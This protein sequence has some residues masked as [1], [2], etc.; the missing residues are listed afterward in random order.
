M[1]RNQQKK[2]TFDLV[3]DTA[4]RLTTQ[5]GVLSISI[6]AIAKEAGCSVAT[7]YRHF[8]TKEDIALGLWNRF[9]I[10]YYILPKIEIQSRNLP[11]ECEV[12]ACY[13]CGIY[14][15]LSSP[16]RSG[17]QF[18]PA[19]PTFFENGCHN[20]VLQSRHL[21]D[22]VAKLMITPLTQK[23]VQN[24]SNQASSSIALLNIST[25]ALERGLCLQLSNPL[26][27]Q[28]LQ[29]LTFDNIF[30]IFQ[31]HL[32]SLKLESCSADTVYQL[33]KDVDA[34]INDDEVKDFFWQSY[35]SLFLENNLPAE[36]LSSKAKQLHSLSRL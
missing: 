34:N 29:P 1:S 32:V 31:T 9:L 12:Y 28:K 7:I 14:K 22:T 8:P 35:D 21:L 20:L 10:R 11:F 27:R 13:L 4:A 25:L 36:H 5:Q 26:T 15:S 6:P 17:V 23:A 24:D 30:T 2:E 3:L 33:L 16:D 18:L 19:M